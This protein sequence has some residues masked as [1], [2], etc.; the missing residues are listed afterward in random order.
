MFDTNHSGDFDSDEEVAAALAAGAAVDTG[1]VKSFVCPV[2]PL[3][4]PDGPASGKKKKGG[5]EKGE[6]TPPQGQLRDC[7]RGRGAAQTIRRLRG[8]SVDA[9]MR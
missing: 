8:A 5:G 6:G 7:A 9:E 2:I 3:P 4:V 1:V